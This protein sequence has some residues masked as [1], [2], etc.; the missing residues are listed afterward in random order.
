MSDENHTHLNQPCFGSCF[1]QTGEYKKLNLPN[2]KGYLVNK[3]KLWNSQ[4]IYSKIRECDCQ[5]KKCL[6]CGLEFPEWVLHA[7][8]GKCAQCD[9]LCCEN[10]TPGD[11][12]Y[13][14]NGLCHYCGTKLI[15][16]RASHDWDSRL[17]HKKCWKEFQ[18]DSN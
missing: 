10:E 4:N 17:Y 7:S 18:E 11:C 9:M 12:L 13:V 1:E 5:L 6:C 16:F 3:T 2:K 8:R 15:P 14:E